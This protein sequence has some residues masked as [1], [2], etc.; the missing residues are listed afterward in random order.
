MSG[1]ASVTGTISP[2]QMTLCAIVATVR[3]FSEGP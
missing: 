3:P 1:T 2:S